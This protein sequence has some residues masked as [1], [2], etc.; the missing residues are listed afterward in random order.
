MLQE[1]NNYEDI[2]QIM[3]VA[4]VADFFLHVCVR[5]ILLDSYEA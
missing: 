5:V 1:Q 4:P 2:T 3:N